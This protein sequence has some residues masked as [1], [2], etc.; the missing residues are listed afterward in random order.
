MMITRV[1]YFQESGDKVYFKL[2]DNR[3]EILLQLRD[4]QI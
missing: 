1:R 2:L 3:I 4:G